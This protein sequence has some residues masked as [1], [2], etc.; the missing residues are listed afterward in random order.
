MH[1]DFTEI[2][3]LSNASCVS[4]FLSFT[5][6]ITIVEYEIFASFACLSG[7]DVRT[8]EVSMVYA[9]SVPVCWFRADFAV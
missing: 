2:A 1:I 3:E 7:T 4:I 6:T 8:S 5:I 9:L